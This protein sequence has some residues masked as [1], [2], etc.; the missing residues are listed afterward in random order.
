MPKKIS[1]HPTMSNMLPFCGVTILYLQHGPYPNSTFEINFIQF[2]AIRSFPIWQKLY[3]DTCMYV[4][5][6]LYKVV[7]H[8]YIYRRE[9]RAFARAHIY[10]RDCREREN[11]K[12]YCQVYTH[13]HLLSNALIW[14]KDLK[15]A[16]IIFF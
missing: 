9:G 5:P 14:E 12:Y 1:Q 15:N 10:T 4:W 8:I 6:N 7:C 13:T 11:I 16:I 3:I 2:L